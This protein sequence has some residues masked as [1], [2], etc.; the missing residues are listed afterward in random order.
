VKDK[1][2]TKS[3]ILT[4]YISS[5]LKRWFRNLLSVWF[6]RRVL[7]LQ[8]VEAVCVGVSRSSARVITS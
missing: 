4:L 5:V 3:V 8:Q 7:W 6:Q 1:V 2:Y